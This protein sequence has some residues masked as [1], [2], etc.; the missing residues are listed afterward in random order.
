MDINCQYYTETGE[1]VC[2]FP[3]IQTQTIGSDTFYYSTLWSGADVFICFFLV[4]FLII[5]IVE[6][7]LKIF[8]PEVV[9]IKRKYD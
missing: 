8:F 1:F 7:L 2:A 3:Y 9:K 6:I 4:C 5:Y